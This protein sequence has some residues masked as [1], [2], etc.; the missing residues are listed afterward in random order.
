[1]ISVQIKTEP[2]VLG[3]PQQICRL[4]MS[5]ESLDDLF[6]EKGLHQWIADFLSI[7]ITTEDRFS[8]AICAMCRQRLTEFHHFRLRSQ[9]VQTVLQSMVQDE[10]SEPEKEARGRKTVQETKE[11]KC[12]RCGKAFSKRH[13]LDKHVKIH[14]KH[15]TNGGQNKT[16]SSTNIGSLK[17]RNE[18]SQRHPGQQPKRL[19]PVTD[20]DPS[21]GNEDMIDIVEVKIEAQTRTDNDAT[22]PGIL[23]DPFFNFDGN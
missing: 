7:Q 22:L 12:V 15:V 6:K 5:K 4:C 2:G 13:H 23:E 9:E 17:S 11:H 21:I 20:G 16:D 3:N 8:K 14:K 19:F 10:N 18:T 1:M